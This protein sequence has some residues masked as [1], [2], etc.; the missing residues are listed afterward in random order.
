MKSTPVNIAPAKKAP[1]AIPGTSNKNLVRLVHVNRLSRSGQLLI[2]GA[3][4]EYKPQKRA[5]TV[6]EISETNLI[7]MVVCPGKRPVI[8]VSGPVIEGTTAC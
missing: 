5:I 6:Q 2:A 8:E 1:F 7:V 4:A 3:Q